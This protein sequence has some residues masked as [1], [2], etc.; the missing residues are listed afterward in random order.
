MSFKT[1][2]SLKPPLDSAPDAFL[3]CYTH[4]YVNAMGLSNVADELIRMIL[5]RVGLKDLDSF[6]SSSDVIRRVAC[7]HRL[8]E[9]EI[10][11]LNLRKWTMTWGLYGAVHFKKYWISS[12]MYFGWWNMFRP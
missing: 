10:Q 12:C 8:A 7:K 4:A 5:D 1:R 2:H 6:L 9:H 11:K 3:C